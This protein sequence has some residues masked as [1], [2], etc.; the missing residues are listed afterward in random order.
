[1]TRKFATPILPNCKDAP[2]E[3]YAI[4]MSF[5]EP[6]SSIRMYFLDQSY[7]AALIQGLTAID[8][9]DLASPRLTGVYITKHSE[10]V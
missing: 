5:S 4:T 9:H 7:A 2:L 8:A 1:M 6:P 10:P 3:R